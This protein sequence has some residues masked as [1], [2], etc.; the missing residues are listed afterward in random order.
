MLSTSHSTYR[1]N[2]FVSNIL[3]FAFQGLFS[4]TRQP[5]NTCNR[6]RPLICASNGTHTMHHY[7]TS[8]TPVTL[9]SYEYH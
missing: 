2:D 4:D 8:T 7:S 6:I 9:F 1:H 5:R 3:H